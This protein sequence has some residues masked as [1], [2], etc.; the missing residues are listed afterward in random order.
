[1]T[2]SYATRPDFLTDNYISTWLLDLPGNSLHH[3]EIET[4]GPTRTEEEVTE[5]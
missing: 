5:E 2:Q 1:M 4:T 3:H